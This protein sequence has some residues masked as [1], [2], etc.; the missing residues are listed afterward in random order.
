MVKHKHSKNKPSFLPSSKAQLTARAIFEHHKGPL[1]PAE[2]LA[3]YNDV[4]PDAAERII[5]MAEQQVIHRHVLEKKVID[6][7][8]RNSQLGLRYG[9]IIGLVAILGGILCI[10][11]GKEISGSIIGGTGVTGLVSVFVY[12]SSQRRKE[13][14]ARLK[15]QIGQE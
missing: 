15:Q 2:M 11:L 10:V 7:D 5:T 3:K 13:R 9:L 6:S 14:E 4:V 1:P 12:G 8:I